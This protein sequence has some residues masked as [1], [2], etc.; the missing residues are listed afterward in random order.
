MRG[1][2]LD[3]LM[4]IK[5][6]TRLPPKPS[7]GAMQVTQRGSLG[8][9]PYNFLPRENMVWSPLRKTSSIMAFFFC[10]LAGSTFV[11]LHSHR[12]IKQHEG[13]GIENII[14]WTNYVKFIIKC[15]CKSP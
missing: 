12:W 8:S 7:K 1:F 6:R 2:R 10:S 9:S 14:Y 11:I 5:E 4:C 3:R 13:M 15:I